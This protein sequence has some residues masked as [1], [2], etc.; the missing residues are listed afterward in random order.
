[1]DQNNDD[2]EFDFKSTD[3]QYIWLNIRDNTYWFS[4]ETENFVGN[5]PY[6][7]IQEAKDALDLYVKNL[8]V[9]AAMHKKWQGQPKNGF[10]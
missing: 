3:E 8:W 5:G 10:C 6:K 4:D 9:C 2:I 7:T 1:M